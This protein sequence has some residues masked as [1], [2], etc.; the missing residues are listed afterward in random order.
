[1]VA[2]ARQARFDALLGFGGKAHAVTRHKFEQPEGQL[3]LHVEPL[4]RA[5]MDAFGVYVSVFCIGEIRKGIASLPASNRRAV[6]A[7]AVK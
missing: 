1:M 5:E 7:D 3:W 4:G 2:Q 6:F